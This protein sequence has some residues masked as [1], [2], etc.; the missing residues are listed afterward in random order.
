MLWRWE[1]GDPAMAST[2]P[3]GI[4]LTDH[5]LATQL[6][7]FLT[8][9]PPDDAL[10]A[11]A[12]AG[13]LRANL[14]GARGDAARVSGRPGL[15][16]DDHRDVLPAQPVAGG[17]GRYGQC[18]RSSR[19]RCAADLGIEARMFLDNVLWNGDLT[20]LLLSRTAFLNSNLATMIYAVRR[21]AG[22]DADHLRRRRRCRPTG[23]RGC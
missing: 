22:R 5:E 2:S 3:A 15:A 16:A 7:F 14:A 9:R 6:A 17:A 13:T 4:P 1:L 12:R 19:R 20:D 11:A 8:D 23:G 21:A 10:L 18:F